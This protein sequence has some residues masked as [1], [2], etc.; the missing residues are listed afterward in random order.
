MA[1]NETTTFTDD[2]IQTGREK[3][4]SQQPEVGWQS[5]TIGGVTGILMGAGAMYALDAYGN[6]PA[7]E[8]TVNNNGERS[9]GKEE[10]HSHVGSNGLKVADVDENLSF[11]DA[12]QTAREAVGPG[13]V[14][15]WHGNIYNTYTADEWNGMSAEDR[16]QFAQQVQPEIRPSEMHH[17]HRHDVAQNHEPHPK[18]DEPVKEK[19]EGEPAKPESEQAEP[20]NEDGEVHFLGFEN[21]NIDGQEH[22]AGHMTNA[23][24][25]VYFVD[26][27]NDPDHL[28]DHA[29]ADRNGDGSLTMNEAVEFDGKVTME[30][31]GLLSQIESS[32]AN[33]SNGQLA[34]NTQD[35]IATDMPDYMNDAN[36]VL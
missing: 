24:R 16:A 17:E 23:G 18:T 28:I 2:N 10:I 4:E 1:T 36:T 5:V 6:E 25:H 33:S 14:F 11:G 20:Q 26:M 19:P 27:D 15:H 29:I 30:E 31:F 21:I 7:A 8:E 3:K 34:Q 13:G 32:S 22:V 35:S 9:D 12:F